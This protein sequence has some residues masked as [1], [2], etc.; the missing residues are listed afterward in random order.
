MINRLRAKFISITMIL[1]VVMLLVILGLIV[2]FTRVEL[3]NRSIAILQSVTITPEHPGEQGR[4]L[5]AMPEPCFMLIQTARGELKAVG[6]GHFDLTDEALLRQILSQAKATGEETGILWSH[7]LRFYHMNRGA[8]DRYAF[9]DITSEG[10]T[11]WNLFVN[12]CLI[13]MV[14]MVVF[15]FIS[16]LLARWMVKPVEESWNRQRQFLADA[17]HELKTPLTVILTNA[18]LLRSE[19]YDVEAKQRFTNSILTMSAQMRGLVEHMLELAR[20]D[21]GS[22]YQQMDRLNL[23]Q[24]AGETVLTF[25]ALYFEAGRQLCSVIAPDIR[26]QGS[27]ERLRQVIE[28]LLDN[29]CKYSRRGTAVTLTLERQGHSHCILSVA[30]QGDAL[31]ARQCKDIFKRFYRVDAARKMNHSYGLGLPIAQ[32]IVTG[33]KGKIWCQSK[34]GVNTFYVSL[35]I[36]NH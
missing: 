24:L 4:G 8:E 18:E 19:E 29:G 9:M 7:S 14:A 3:E 22:V 21:H 33:H 10:Q 15:F 31:T 1:F 30:S 17:S 16:W 20:V 2:Q 5:A 12:C 35:P 36:S 34:E 27:S 25:E 13:G 6:S 26:V 28:I 11:L 32:S 23:S